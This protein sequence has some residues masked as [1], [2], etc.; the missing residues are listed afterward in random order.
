MATEPL[1]NAQTLSVVIADPG[2][3]IVS[4]EGS[5][6]APREGLLLDRLVSCSVYP[7][8]A[9]Q[10][11]LELPAREDDQARREALKGLKG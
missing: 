8:T 10:I 6:N 11:V 5:P 2:E 4:V 1:L 3:E 7:V 9:R